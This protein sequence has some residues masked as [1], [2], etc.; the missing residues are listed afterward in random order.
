M[1]WTV[2]VSRCLDEK[3]EMFRLSLTTYLQLHTM[4]CTQQQRSRQSIKQQSRDLSRITLELQQ[5]LSHYAIA[6][7]NSVTLALAI[8]SLDLEL[9]SDNSTHWVATTSQLQTLTKVTGIKNLIFKLR[10]HQ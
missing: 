6:S 5:V 1:F 4:A 3:N 10:Y 9:I 7:Y 8:L 2:V